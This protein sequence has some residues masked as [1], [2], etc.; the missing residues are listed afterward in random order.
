MGVVDDTC[1]YMSNYKKRVIKYLLEALEKSIKNWDELLT[2]VG[3]Q[4]EIETN[5]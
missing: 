2:F 3:G 5:D 4:L 1:H